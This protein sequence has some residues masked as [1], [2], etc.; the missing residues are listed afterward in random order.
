MGVSPP[1]GGKGFPGESLIGTL[2]CG[3]YAAR[4]RD[5]VALLIALPTARRCCK[6]L[7]APAA[8]RAD[9]RT[10]EYRCDTCVS[11]PRVLCV[12]PPT[13]RD[14]EPGLVG[15]PVVDMLSY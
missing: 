4:A 13:H 1:F 10:F 8:P 14:S 5:D 12:P 9:G 15:E 6:F 3:S 11:V 7:R 2:L